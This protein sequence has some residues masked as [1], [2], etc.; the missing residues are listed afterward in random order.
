LYT[1]LVMFE[2]HC[3]HRQVERAYRQGKRCTCVGENMSMD[4]IM[5]IIYKHHNM[6]M[7]ISN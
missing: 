1:M 3:K 2:R 6:S 7:N 5:I 4:I